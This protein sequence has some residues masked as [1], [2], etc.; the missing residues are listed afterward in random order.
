MS[1]DSEPD[2][3]SPLYDRYNGFLLGAY[4]AAAYARRRASVFTPLRTRMQELLDELEIARLLPLDQESFVRSHADLAAE[5]APALKEASGELFNFFLLGTCAVQRC[6]LESADDLAEVR[7]VARHVL[8][9]HDLS[10]E[11]WD[12]TF[13]VR[14]ESASPLRRAMPLL[15]AVLAPLP[16]EEETCFVAQPPGENG[17]RDFERFFRVLLEACGKRSIRTLA[18]FGGERRQEVLVQAIRRSGSLLADISGFTPDVVFQLGVARG[19]GKRVYLFTSTAELEPPA[20][21]ALRW[22]C[23]F[24]PDGAHGAARDLGEGLYFITAV[25]AVLDS[26]RGGLGEVTPERVIGHLRQAEAFARESPA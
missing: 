7:R 14:E 19:A 5:L 3:H 20:D 8:A 15:A 18:G 6:G 1:V 24:T 2:R 26:D 4:F 21:L 16:E 11:L 17:A 10:R 12:S 9:T 13:Q 23:R 22:I 25:D